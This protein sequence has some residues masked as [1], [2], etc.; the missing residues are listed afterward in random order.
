[1]RLALL[2]HGL[3]EANERRLYCGSSDLPLSEAG[4]REIRERAA[5]GIYPPPDGFEL[6]TSG[7]LRTE[8]TLSLIYGDRPRRV[9]VRL[10][11]LDFGDFELRSYDELK[12]D[13]AYLRWISGDNEA[14]RCPNGE[15][16]E[17][18]KKRVYA[19]LDDFI[20]GGADIVAVTHGGVVAAIM[21][22]LFPLEGKNR[23]EWQ[24]RAGE[25]FLVDLSGAGAAYR[26]IA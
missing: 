21:E 14:K 23:Y 12:D 6:Y 24:P 4:A 26:E 9:D 8:Q 25:G 7:L 5:R 2:R 1:M 11:E 19:A 17:D 18:L 22:R 15:S 20:K 13:P 3:T 16:G 10:R